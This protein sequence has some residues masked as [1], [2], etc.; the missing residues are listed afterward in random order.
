MANIVDW[1][2]FGQHL[3]HQF[4]SITYCNS[5]YGPSFPV[6]ALIWYCIFSVIWFSIYSLLWSIFQS[7]VF[8]IYLVFLIWSN[9]PARNILVQKSIL[10]SFL[11]I[12]FHSLKLFKSPEKSASNFSVNFKVL[13]F[14][15]KSFYFLI[16]CLQIYFID[17]KGILEKKVLVL[18]AFEKIRNGKRMKAD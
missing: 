16:F 4:L 15:Y 8:F 3:C 11:I 12:A 1:L 7:S 5:D 17:F 9:E 13:C 2:F 10:K 14:S 18:C 6:H